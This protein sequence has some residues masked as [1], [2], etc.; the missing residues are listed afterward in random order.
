MPT[1]P[2]AT[3]PQCMSVRACVRALPSID[4]P[5]RAKTWM[6]RSGNVAL[7]LLC[8]DVGMEWTGISVGLSGR[9]H[10][11]TSGSE[12]AVMVWSCVVGLWT[13]NMNEKIT[14]KESG[15]GSVGGD[16]VPWTMLS[17]MW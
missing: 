9:A 17:G 5:C 3:W 15:R 4:F 13:W 6:P 11:Q 14:G 7:A 2:V 1:F 8:P 12:S 10:G 16:S